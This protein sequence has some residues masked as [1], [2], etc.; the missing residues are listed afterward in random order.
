MRGAKANAHAFTSNPG[1]LEQAIAWR[2]DGKSYQWIA[3]QFHVSLSFIYNQLKQADSAPETGP[4]SSSTCLP[5]SA[6]IIRLYSAGVSPEKMGAKL[7]HDP[8][9]IRLLLKKMGRLRDTKP[10]Q[11]LI[12]QHW[13]DEIDTEVKAYFLGLMA[14]DGWL[15][16][17][18]LFLGLKASD[19][20]LLDA[21]RQRAFPFIPIREYPPKELN[22]ESQQRISITCK[23]WADRLRSIGITEA[24]SLTLGDVTSQIPEPVRHHFARGYFDGDGSISHSKYRGKHTVLISIRGTRPFLTGLWA[25]TGIPVGG[26]Y[27]KQGD[28]I[29]ALSISGRRRMHELHDYLYRDAT[30]F[31]ERKREKFTW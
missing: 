5:D 29:K 17:N 28:G 20:H 26:I 19:G 8:Q 25:A 1:A 3:S 15:N 2:R 6:H 18:T 4:A 27:P 14:S 7:G 16:K 9:A 10:Y 21:V 24:K 11:K 13:L 22:V 12:D 23:R 30:L 31:L